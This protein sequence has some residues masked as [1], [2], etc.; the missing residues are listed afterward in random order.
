V[1]K[2]RRGIEGLPLRLMLVALLI[3]LT[4]PSVLS[5]MQ[6]AT[7]GIAEDKVAEMAEDIAVTV[8]EMSMG[9]PGNVRV[10]TV[11]MDL[12]DGAVLTIGGGH[13][14]ADCAR[15]SWTIDGREGFRYLAGVVIITEGG[16]PL[17]ISAGD[18][19][20]FVCPPGTWGTVEA[21]LA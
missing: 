17:R 4:L 5:L 16:G 15:I 8:E 13:G 6:N 11:P 12:P 20:R 2:D 10:V 3:S 14:P 9:G 1:R 7:S 18:S 19:V 21:A